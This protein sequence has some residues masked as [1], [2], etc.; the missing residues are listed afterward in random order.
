VG[1]VGSGVTAAAAL[2]GGL[3]GTRRNSVDIAGDPRIAANQV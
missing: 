1:I 3:M 2:G